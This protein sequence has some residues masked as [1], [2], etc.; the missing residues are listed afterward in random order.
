MRNV[1]GENG[2]SVK[3]PTNLSAGK[4]YI[5]HSGKITADSTISF[6]KFKYDAFGHITGTNN[7]TSADVLA[8]G[9]II[10]GGGIGLSVNSTNKKV[11][12][13]KAATATALGGVKIDNSKASIN[14]LSILPN[15]TL[16][17]CTV[18]PSIGS[19]GL[20]G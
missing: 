7:V 6:K 20:S 4:L 11:L 19:N 9:N 13:L 17:A 1:V 10:S 14:N 18:D 12:D 2:I 3:L 15:G 16:S 5:G 8:L